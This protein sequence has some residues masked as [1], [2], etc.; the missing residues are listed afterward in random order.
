MPFGEITLEMFLEEG[1]RIPNG[2]VHMY[3]ALFRRILSI[4]IL[5]MGKDAGQGVE[6]ADTPEDMNG[7]QRCV[8]QR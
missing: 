7:R 3:R 6:E 8:L 4:F 2:T 1:I 5:K